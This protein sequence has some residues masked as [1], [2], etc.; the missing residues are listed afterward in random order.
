MS[1]ASDWYLGMNEYDTMRAHHQ[2][3]ENAQNLYDQHYG[4]NDDY[5]P[6]Q[7]GP[8]QNLGYRNEG[9]YGGGNGGYGGG[10]SGYGGGRGG[11]DSGY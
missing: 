5:N 1:A 7:Q 11:G 3:K 2:A 10:D 9:R 4:G 6:N 8:P